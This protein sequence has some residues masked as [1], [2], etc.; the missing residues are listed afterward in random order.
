MLRESHTLRTVKL[1]FT[2]ALVKRSRV[3]YLV[4]ITA[5]T[6][7]NIVDVFHACVKMLFRLEQIHYICAVTFQ[8]RI[9]IQKAG[10]LFFQCDF[11]I[12][13]PSLIRFRISKFRYSNSMSNSSKNICLRFQAGEVNRER[14]KDPQLKKNCS[15][16]LTLMKGHLLLRNLKKFERSHCM[17]NRQTTIPNNMASIEGGNTTYPSDVKLLGINQLNLPN[18]N[19]AVQ[20]LSGSSSVEYELFISNA[21]ATQYRR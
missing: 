7:G 2:S 5:D 9:A 10:L 18:L 8:F 3:C 6:T 11:K 17:L 13:F 1:Q 12:C 4:C 21:S 15:V 20:K 16:F 14:Q 19:E